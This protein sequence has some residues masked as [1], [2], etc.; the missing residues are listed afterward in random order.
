LSEVTDHPG[1]ATVPDASCGIIVLNVVSFLNAKPLN[2][3]L[4]TVVS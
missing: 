1:D 3:S 2:I 4:A